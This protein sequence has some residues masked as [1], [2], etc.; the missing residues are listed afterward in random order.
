MKNGKKKY[1]NSGTEK[2]IKMD[3][4]KIK[5]LVNNHSGRSKGPTLY[6]HIQILERH[7]SIHVK[8]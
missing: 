1:L 4:K 2:L 6:L 5:K 3:L 7:F 8:E